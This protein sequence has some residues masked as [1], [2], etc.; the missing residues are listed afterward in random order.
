MLQLCS[1]VSDFPRQT[2]YLSA[3]IMRISAK[4][5]RHKAE[6]RPY[7]P[8][9]SPL[10]MLYAS[11]TR[12]SQQSEP[13]TNSFCNWWC[14]PGIP[15]IW[16]RIHHIQSSRNTQS[17]PASVQPTRCILHNFYSANFVDLPLH[18][19]DEQPVHRNAFL[20]EV[21]S[22]LSGRKYAFIVTV[23]RGF[24]SSPAM[25]ERSRLLARTKP[26]ILWTS[27]WN[28]PVMRKPDFAYTRMSG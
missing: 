22:L 5:I 12:R 24:L 23:V 14:L 19:L 21:G 10:L 15:R 3:A 27:W 18:I 28:G 8:F 11:L 4:T 17:Q 6:R 25:T 16:H 13:T 26:P 20:V 2:A 9:M 7:I 1:Q